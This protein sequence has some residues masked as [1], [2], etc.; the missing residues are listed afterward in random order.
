MRNSTHGAGSFVNAVL[1]MKRCNGRGALGSERF[2][3]GRRKGWACFFFCLLRF[4]PVEKI[5]VRVRIEDPVEGMKEALSLFPP[6]HQPRVPPDACLPAC[7]VPPSCQVPNCL[8]VRPHAPLYY[9][10]LHTYLGT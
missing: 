8:L 9:L 3:C 1:E 5:T 10:L 6:C 7:A 2:D 4:C